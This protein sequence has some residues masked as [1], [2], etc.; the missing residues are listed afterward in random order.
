MAVVA[1]W[2]RYRIVADL[3]TSS[4]PVLLKTH[5]IE[6]RH[7][8]NLSGAQ[9]VGVVVRRGE[10]QLRCHPRHLTMA[11]N[12]VVRRQKPSCS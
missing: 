7:T 6:E 3:V 8:L 10:C 1:K 9:T 4:S 5:G 11:Q 2:S 12:C